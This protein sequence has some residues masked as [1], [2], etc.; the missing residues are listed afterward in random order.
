[1]LESVRNADQSLL[2]ELLPTDGETEST[3]KVSASQLH[4]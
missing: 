3:N 2:R 1:L 4:G